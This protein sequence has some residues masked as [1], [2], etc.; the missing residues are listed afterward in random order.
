MRNKILSFALLAF[1]AI[2]A[3]AAY[4]SFAQAAPVAQSAS[5]EPLRTLN[6]NGHGEVTLTPDIA[7]IYVGVHS[8]NEVASDAVAENNDLAQAVIDA[9]KAAGVKAEDISTTNFSLWFS[10][11]YD[12]NGQPTDGKYVVDNTVYITVRDLEQLGDILGTAIDAGANTVNGI[13]FDV[14]DKE[15]ALA[16]AREKAV[17]D[18]RA[19]AEEL[20]DLAEVELGD[21]QSISMYG[22]FPTPIY[23]GK[24]GGGYAADASLSVPITPGQFVVT[25]DVS[26][27]YVIE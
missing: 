5:S 9:L 15:A 19:Q 14:S 27:V 2:F 24:G 17:D 18:A 7:Y 6:I 8:E 26:I 13:S 12:V 1:I 4:N 20:A 16:E 23:G 22:G 11:N 21:I 25:M 10:Q 3:V